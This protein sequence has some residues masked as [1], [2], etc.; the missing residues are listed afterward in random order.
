MK[1]ETQ[2]K[3]YDH[4][5][6]FSNTDASTIAS[7]TG[8]NRLLVFKTVKILADEKLIKI[9]D[10]NPPTYTLI[11]PD[12]KGEKGAIKK[13]DKEAVEKEKDEVITKSEGR[14]TEKLKFNG[15]LY[16]K[17]KLVLAVVRKYI[18]DNPKT[19]LTKLKEVFPDS[20]QPRYGVVQEIGKAKKLSEDRDRFFLKPEDLIKVGDKK[21]A[22]CN[23]F[24]S[25]NL[26]LKH[27]K[28]MGF[29]IK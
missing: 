26:P 11:K 29:I 28:S 13:A 8:V 25:H 1:T 23:Q 7:A 2:K 22:V 15:E 5:E 18:L 10:T 20:L 21:I 4:I 6:K 14:N 24:G 17:G 16:G 9:S 27:F 19:T 12:A 3:I